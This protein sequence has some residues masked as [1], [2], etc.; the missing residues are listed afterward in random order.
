MA[1]ITVLCFR[2]FATTQAVSLHFQVSLPH[3]PSSFRRNWL[4][5]NLTNFH[6]TITR[7]MLFCF[8]NSHG[9]FCEGKWILF[10]F[11]SWFPDI[12]SPL[13]LKRICICELP[14]P[15]FSLSSF[16]PLLLSY[17]IAH[18]PFYYKSWEVNWNV[19]LL[20]H[21]KKSWNPERNT[22]QLINFCYLVWF[23]WLL[24]F[25]FSSCLHHPFTSLGCRD[26]WRLWYGHLGRKCYCFSLL[27]FSYVPKCAQGLVQLEIGRLRAG[28]W[29]A[30]RKTSQNSQVV[31]GF[32]SDW[33]TH[34]PVPSERRFPIS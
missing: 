31:D 13:S 22:I 6:S 3:G 17:L 5:K 10:I 14:P 1:K 8:T 34:S 12:H 18:R 9:S 16:S 25:L 32:P 4:I 26:E 11:K 19:T 7:C 2:G 15:L 20:T 24:N 23:F 21:L 33:H 30:S 28:S 29:A 27:S